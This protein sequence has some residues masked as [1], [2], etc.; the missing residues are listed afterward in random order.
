[1]S[2]V[3]ISGIEQ[4]NIMSLTFHAR[5]AFVLYISE[6]LYFCCNEFLVI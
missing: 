5:H 1:M 3:I 6:E 4:Y 2:L